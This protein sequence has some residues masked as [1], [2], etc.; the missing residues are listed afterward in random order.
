MKCLGRG[1]AELRAIAEELRRHG[2]ELELLSG[3]LQGI[4]NPSQHGAALCAFCRWDG[5]V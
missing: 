2:I 5:R 4:Y 3:P 1:A